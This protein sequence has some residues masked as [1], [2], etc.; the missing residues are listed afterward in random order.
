MKLIRVPLVISAYSGGQATLT[1]TPPSHARVVAVGLSVDSKAALRDHE[2]TEIK[3]G[4]LSFLTRSTVS[5]TEYGVSL[6]HV[7]N[8]IDY[9]D[10]STE[11]YAAAHFRPWPGRYNAT[12]RNLVL[13]L[14]A[15]QGE[16]LTQQER[17]SLFLAEKVPCRDFTFIPIDANVEFSVT[18]KRIH[19]ATSIAYA[20]L[21]CIEM[22]AGE[23]DLVC[24]LHKLTDYPHWLAHT[25]ILPAAAGLSDPVECRWNPNG[26]QAN[27]ALRIMHLLAMGHENNGGTI[28]YA[29]DHLNA[30]LLRLAAGDGNALQPDFADKRVRLAEMA[31]QL[32]QHVDCARQPELIVPWNSSIQLTAQRLA[33]DY[34]KQIRLCFYGLLRP[35]EGTTIPDAA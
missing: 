25:L 34:E 7:A 21:W 35:M 23:K 11:L 29:L 3:H 17:V 32:L 9:E 2:V 13:T 24:S 14:R 4:S 26:A 12:M 5:S 19:G 18:V 33:S 22:D 30:V 31:P 8:H 16:T 6:G 27:H 20:Y 1:W 10:L 28:A 15:A